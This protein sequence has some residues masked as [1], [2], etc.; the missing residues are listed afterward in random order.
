MLQ[1]GL[2]EGPETALSAC[3]PAIEIRETGVFYDVVLIA[4]IQTSLVFLGFR[5]TGDSCYVFWVFEVPNVSM[6]VSSL[7]PS[8]EQPL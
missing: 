5:M 4:I 7:C 2:L 8:L 1:N 6:L 3:E